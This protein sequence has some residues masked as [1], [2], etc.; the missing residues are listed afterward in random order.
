M[1][2]HQ[3]FVE[4][5][6]DGLYSLRHIPK[7]LGQTG[8]ETIATQC[9]ENCVQGPLPRRNDEYSTLPGGPEATFGSHFVSLDRFAFRAAPRTPER[10]SST[11][12]TEQTWP[13]ITHH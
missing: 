8:H 6:N 12:E 3:G 1:F 4:L 5:L 2:T 11:A 10:A 9:L 13:E 7:I